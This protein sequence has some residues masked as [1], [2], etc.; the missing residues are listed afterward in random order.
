MRKKI[1]EIQEKISGQK[2]QERILYLRRRIEQLE[3]QYTDVRLELGKSREL[4]ESIKAAV[5]A[6]KPFPTTYQR[7]VSK[8]LKPATAV[9]LFSDWHIGE[10]ISK[11]ETEGFGNFNYSIAEHRIFEIVESF[12]RW[13]E[14]QRRSYSIRKCAIIGIGDYISGDIHRELSVTNEFPT[15]VQTAKAG[16]LMGESIRRLAPA[17]EVLKF[18]GVG[19]DN[20]GRLTMKGEFKRK[21]LSGM[22]FL[23][24]ALCESYLSG[25]KNVKIILAPGI[26]HLVQIEGRNF[27]VEHGDAVRA[28]MGIPYYGLERLQGREARRR[29][30]TNLGFDYHVIGHWHVPGIISRNILMNGSLSGT[31]EYDHAVGRFA[32]PCQAAF[33][34]NRNHG[35]FNWTAFAVK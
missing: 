29:M 22:G 4:V 28:W 23:V 32:E 24:H 12:L 34:V 13:V 35:V 3:K 17:F 6:A 9:M 7:A 30:R 15:P 2:A 5:V 20:H 33:L 31:N 1:G 27:L 16:L 26:K 21:A 25:H 8:K 18:Y 14:T 11:A 19:A 10:I